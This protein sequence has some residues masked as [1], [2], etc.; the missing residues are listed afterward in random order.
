MQLFVLLL[1]FVFA[2]AACTGGADETATATATPVPTPTA[3]PA[4]ALPEPTATSTPVPEPTATVEPTPT[5]IPEVDDETAIRAVHTKFMV[6]LFARDERVDGRG[7]QLP[8]IDELT[9]GAQNA[10]MKEFIVT[11]EERGLLAVGPGHDSNISEVEIIGDRAT[12]FD[13][14]QGRAEGWSEDGELIVP[15]DDFWKWRNTK[16]VKIDDVWFVE[17]FII[18][19]E[20]RCDPNTFADL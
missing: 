8:L 6:D 15:A 7:T 13:C 11:L 3:V 2:A 17:D 4:T 14:S 12:V 19:G 5:E 10:R 16:L 1:V 9:V 20:I 18:G